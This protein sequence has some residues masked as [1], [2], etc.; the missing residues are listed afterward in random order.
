MTTNNVGKISQVIGAVVDV[1]F[2]ADL[3]PMLNA[4][5]TEN[6]GRRLVLEVA[7]HL[8]EKTVRTIAMDSTEGLVRGQKVTDAGSATRVA[9]R[10]GE[11]TM[12]LSVM[13][14][15]HVV[16]AG[17]TRPFPPYRRPYACPYRVSKCHSRSSP[18]AVQ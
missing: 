3:P 1:Q 6:Q 11:E 13:N 2:E 17:R 4:L 18:A 15:R 14:R 5:H 7:Q 8:G 9:A 10:R 16:A 12:T